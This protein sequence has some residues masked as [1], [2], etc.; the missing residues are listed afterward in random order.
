MENRSVIFGIENVEVNIEKFMEVC[1]RY[2]V[3][4][5]RKIPML[6]Y[7]PQN[8]VGREIRHYYFDLARGKDGYLH[9]E[10]VLRPVTEQPLIR[11]MQVT[12]IFSF[13]E[14]NVQCPYCKRDCQFIDGE[15]NIIGTVEVDLIDLFRMAEKAVRENE[16]VRFS[17]GDPVMFQR[18]CLAISS[19]VFEL[20]NSKTSIAHNGS[21][22]FWVKQMLPFMD[23]AAIDLKAVPERMGHIMGITE[24][25][26]KKMH[27]RSLQTQALFSSTELNINKA[28][29]DIRT[30][31]FGNTSI[32]DMIR[33]GEDIT[34]GNPQ[35][36]FWTWRLYKKVHGCDWLV[37]EKEKVIEMLAEVSAKYP[38]HWMGIRAK[39]HGGGMLYFRNGQVVNTE[40]KLDVDEIAGS[41]NKDGCV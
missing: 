5:H 12:R 41:G 3:D 8:M 6:P 21:G 40:E 14:C 32:D 2:L 36:T 39:W 15:G 35:L 37:P 19:Y 30:P 28:I 1:N 38:D 4:H 13:G 20:Y 10:P 29:L 16:I 27:E 17:G 26:G 9:S 33:L 25:G 18:V 22:T 11:N 7:G 24:S 23:S 31:I 34:K